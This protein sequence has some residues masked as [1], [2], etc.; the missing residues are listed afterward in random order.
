MITPV[1]DIAEL[2]SRLIE[3]RYDQYIG[4]SFFLCVNGIY[5]EATEQAIR[6]FQKTHGLM[7][8]GKADPITREI[9]NNA[10]NACHLL[11]AHER[12]EYGRR[13][14]LLTYAN[15][16]HTEHGI[17]AKLVERLQ[18]HGQIHRISVAQLVAMAG[19]LDRNRFLPNW[20]GDA[21]IADNRLVVQDIRGRVVR[22]SLNDPMPT[23]EEVM[24]RFLEEDR[25]KAEE[26]EDVL[27][28]K[29][30]P[31]PFRDGPLM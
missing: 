15:P 31:R 1:H 26:L 19:W 6:C 16:S 27:N 22:M 14:P 3:M 29:K 5:D 8:T 7:M 11:D 25:K 4:P 2:Q 23:A 24:R 20:Q 12:Y 30:P 13:V 28:K 21:F 9:M 17:Y 18:A 10:L